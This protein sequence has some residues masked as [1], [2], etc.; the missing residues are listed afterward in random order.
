[1]DVSS[2]CAEIVRT[3][4]RDRYLSDLFAPATIRPHLFALHAFNTDVAR[5]RDSVSQ[6][7]LGEIRLQWW[8]DALH[9]DPGGHPIASS[10]K[11]AIAEFKLPL[12]AFDNLLEAR[13]FDLY[14]DPM[15]SLN[16][17]E[18]Y[19]G[20]TSSALMQ[21]AAIILAGGKD[22][23][24]TELSG[25]GGVAYALAGLLRA[26]PTHAQRRQCYLPG[27]L[28]AKH[29]V[30]LD[31]IFAG[32]TTPP[33]LALLAEMRA[34]A[35]RHLDAAR[36]LIARIDP[37]LMPAYLPLALVEPSLRLLE[38]QDLDPLRTPTV[39]APWRRHFILWRAARR[40]TGLAAS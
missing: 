37:A 11:T 27:D 3:G 23:G 17:L 33:L 8:H 39:L 24:T 4:D 14:D 5:I 36:K 1:M 16:D 13:K 25:H 10:V 34:I 38:K 18:G 9:G 20:E 19:A 7:M 2:Q 12:E 32:R 22:P 15:P 29:H 40:R 21:L 26:L 30:D 28:L 31:D 6:P 35:R